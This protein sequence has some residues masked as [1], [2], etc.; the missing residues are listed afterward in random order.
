MMIEVVLEAH[1][2]DKEIWR[3]VVGYEGLYKVSN[4][5]RI[6]SLPRNGT[7]KYERLLR[8]KVGNNG[9]CTVALSKHNKTKYK[10]VHRLVAEAFLDNPKDLPLI[11]HKDENKLNN[12]VDNLEWCDAHYNM[13]YGVHAERQYLSRDELG[14][15]CSASKIGTR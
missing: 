6:K 3:D 4:F 2:V 13:T 1:Q 11:N 10:S 9:Y 15:F 12:C 8:Q 14:R 5:G 7:V